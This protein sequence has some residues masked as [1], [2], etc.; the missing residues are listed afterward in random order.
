MNERRAGK[1]KGIDARLVRAVVLAVWSAFF[2]YLQ[3]SGEMV[4]YLG[5]RTY[6]VV[7]FGAITLGLA[8][9]VHFATLRS[10]PRTNPARSDMVG[11]VT[12][13]VPVLAVAA[14]PRP[15]LGALAASRK[16][17]GGATPGFVAPPTPQAG[18]ALSFIDIHYANE[19]DEFAATLG[20][21]DGT[22]IDLVGFVSE[23][24]GAGGT[25]EMSRFYV[26]CCA[27][28]AIPYSVTVDPAE[29]GG[30]FST[31]TWLEVSGS[32]TRTETE[33]IVAAD[34]VERTAEPKNPYL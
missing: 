28:D 30:D 23:E 24:D 6:W 21:S 7:P 22:P 31:N 12:L 11:F 29:V 15:D 19:S 9:A 14:V 25:F 1:P 18:R 5:P 16:S 10:A 27:A 20:L 33:W 32:L 34:G 17:I 4:R 8:A 2:M 3:F 26:S 13:L